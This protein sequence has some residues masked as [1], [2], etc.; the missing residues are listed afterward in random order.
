MPSGWALA[1]FAARLFAIDPAGTGLILRAAPGA[2]RDRWL[3]ALRDAMGDA[4]IRKL[5]PGICDDRLLGGL[6]LAATLAAGRPVAERGL[7]AEVDGG[8]LLL[9]SAERIS[10]ALAAR[11]AAACDRQ[12]VHAERDGLELRSRARFGLVLLDEAETADEAP[13]ASLM[14]RVAFRLD[15]TAIPLSQCLGA[16]AAAAAASASRTVL[17]QV[18]AGAQAIEA[19]CIAACALGI[20][21]V[22]APLLALGVA[23]LVAASEQRTQVSEADLACAAQLVLGWRARVIPAACTTEEIQGELREKIPEEG[24]NTAEIRALTDIVLEAAR[25]ALPADLLASLGAKHTTPTNAGKPGHAGMRRK[26]AMRGRQIGT[27][28]GAPRSGRRLDLIATLRAAAPWQRLRQGAPGR[29][30]IR[31]QD[32]RT[33]RFLQHGGTLTIFAVDAS[34][35]QAL[36]RMAEVKG[37]VETLLGDCYVRRD[38]VALIAFRGTAATVVLPPTRALARARRCLAGQAAGGGTPLASGIDMA[39]LLG[40]SAILRGRDALVILLTDGRANISRDGRPDRPL[41]RQHAAASAL[42]FRRA[43]LR[44]LLIDTG[45]RP[46]RQAADLAGRMGAIYLALPHLDAGALV[47]VMQHAKAGARGNG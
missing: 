11:I 20:D 13:P 28:C 10:A 4:P 5:P 19:L 26:A 25:T 9:P 16:G 22:R 34:G 45:P 40:L 39:A 12:E 21:S 27:A 7:L 42:A 1:M 44:S 23:R 3:D 30:A 32:L 36:H 43:G 18:H 29:L 31:A 17:P 37:A 15:L 14:E 33:R 38:Q 8:A 47:G 35:S 2:Q 24:E 6:D 41:A 46:E